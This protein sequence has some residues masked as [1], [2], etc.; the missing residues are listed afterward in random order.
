MGLVGSDVGWFQV[1][2]LGGP[3]PGVY[4]FDVCVGWPVCW[5]QMGVLWGCVV[6]TLLAVG[7]ALSE[8]GVCWMVVVEACV[9]V[10]GGLLCVV[11]GVVHS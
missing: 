5:W 10:V 8:G 11:V 6:L 7:I 9:L 4:D 2:P 1:C 3:F